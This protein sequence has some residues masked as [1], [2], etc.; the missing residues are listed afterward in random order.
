[1]GAAIRVDVRGASEPAA[2]RNH[3]LMLRLAD[4][5]D[6]CSAKLNVPKLSEFYDSSALET[7]YDDDGVWFDPGPALAAV[8]A[9]GDHL[10]RNPQ[11]LG[12]AA[13][14]PRRHW[15]GLLAGEIEHCRATLEAAAAAGRPFRF[16]IVS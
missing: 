6:R 9:L 13:D 5:L 4:T 16:L 10:A 15:P 3:S 1:M 11:V 14:S 2:P 7:E 8:R 12:I